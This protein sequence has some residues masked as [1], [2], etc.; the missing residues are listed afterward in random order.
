MHLL[1]L[2]LCC[3]LLFKYQGYTYDIGTNPANAY[4]GEITELE[5]ESYSLLLFDLKN[6]TKMLCRG[7]ADSSIIH[8]IIRAPKFIVICKCQ[9]CQG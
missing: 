5:S 2:L 9:S 8:I 1:C 7:V 6:C 3:T 4:A